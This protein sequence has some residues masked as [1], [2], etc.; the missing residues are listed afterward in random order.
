M[1]KE[2][3]SIRVKETTLNVVQSKVE[4]IRK[5]DISKTGLRLYNE[6]CIGVGGAIGDYDE[7]ELEDRAKEALNLRIPYN[8][9]I[10]EDHKEHMDL[11]K[12]IIDEE[13]F[14]E[15]MEEMLSIL[16][17]NQPGLSFFNKIRLAQ[18]EV[19]MV[20]DKN[21]DLGFKDNYISF[22]LGFKEKT[23]ANL[24]DG[25]VGCEGRYYDRDE[26]LSHANGICNAF[27]NKME[28][29]EEDLPVIFASSD[30]L[31]LKQLIMD[32]H[33]QR[34]GSGSSLLSGK[35]GQRVFNESFTLYQSLDP[36]D[37]YQ[38][39]FD[40]E[41]VVN[42]EYKYPLIENGIVI[43]SYTDKKTAEMFGLPLTGSAAGEYDSV[44]AIGYK[45][46]KIKE[47]Q[48]TVKE[49]LNG[50][51]GIFVMIAAGGDFTPK[52]DFAT[53]VQ[54]AMLFDGERFVGRLPELQISS[55]VF[56][57]FGKDFRGVGKNKV[58]S[59]DNTKLMVMDMKVT[60]A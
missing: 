39:F 43:S 54:L 23:S 22:E 50:Q 34:F 56:D 60:K 12:N 24:F 38:P 44:P 49:L 32:L 42:N 37:T 31:P 52:G 10:S 36:E 55:N 26:F 48:K 45:N 8:Y 51:R 53:P 4:S 7:T 11:A 17:E 27:N 16:E 18:R 35:I 28:L 5:K 47:S 46:F 6:G 33:G 57:M 21:L 25:F 30:M 13:K 1:I 41:G 59:L 14:L 29:P 20:N 19:T 2:K 40:T 58:F 15:E 9:P 3:Y